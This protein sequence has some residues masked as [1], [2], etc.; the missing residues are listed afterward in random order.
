V[1]YR[2][3]SAQRKDSN[4]PLS[5]RVASEA[6]RAHPRR[7]S[8]LESQHLAFLLRLR[9][10]VAPTKSGLTR[11]DKLVSYC[12][13]D[14]RQTAARRCRVCWTAP[15]AIAGTYNCEAKRGCFNYGSP[16]RCR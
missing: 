15:L 4:L 12:S 2:P 11:N 14:G 6:S 10:L 16:T 13:V 9:F 3:I 1:T 5:F 8:S 7:P